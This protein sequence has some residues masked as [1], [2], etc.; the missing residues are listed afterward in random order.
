MANGVLVFAEQRDGVFRGPAFEAL[1]Q[2]RRLAG[3][4]G[5]DLSAAVLGS[6]I[7][8]TVEVLKE[9]GVDA[10]FVAD[11][12]HL[13]RY[14]T[15]GY[16]DVFSKIVREK[17]PSIVLMPASSLG[18][19]LA[20]R[21][22][23]HLETGLITECTALEI[24]DGRLLGTRPVYAG[25]ALIK[26]FVKTDPQMATLRPK[27]FSAETISESKETH[28]E[29]V[30]V[31][32]GAERIRAK[33]IEFQSSGGDRPE[34]TEADIIVSGGRG[35]GNADSFNVIEDLADAL[36][37]AVGASRSAVDAGWRPHP[38]QVGQTGKTV[39]PS[40]YIAC[41]ISGAIQHLAGMSSSKYIVAINKNPD[42]PIF[43]VATY[44]IVGDLF[45]VVPALTEEVKKLQAA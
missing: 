3:Q 35:M 6:G 23:A 41:G 44:G 29:Q 7:A 21:V 10:V 15:E 17:N 4:L 1:T 38:D 43:K 27:V 36:G 22:A 30:D 31:T 9:Y 25:K 2:G 12:E 20:P 45:E 19:D 26:T 40:L 11:S 34:L 5:T 16:A 14:T 42:A 18:R 39:S 13:A 8:G 37:A 24:S 28:V 32:T 33:V